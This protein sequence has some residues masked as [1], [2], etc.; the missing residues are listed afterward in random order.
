MLCQCGVE[1][2]SVFR[3]YGELLSDFAETIEKRKVS[4]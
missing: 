1:R 2:E 4:T 3:G